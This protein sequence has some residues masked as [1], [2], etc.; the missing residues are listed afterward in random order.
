MMYR[1]LAWAAA[2]ILTMAGTASFAAGTDYGGYLMSG[3]FNVTTVLGPAPRPGDPRYKADRKIFLA[4]RRFAGSP[5]WDLAA[6]DADTSVPALLRNFSCSVGVELTPANSPRL[7]AVARRAAIDTSYQT[8]IAKEAYKRRRPYVIDRGAVCQPP[9]ELYDKKAQRMT[10]DYPSG[11]TTLGWTWAVVLSS[12]APDRAQQILERGRAY[13]DS[14][15]VCGVHNQ[16]AVEAG[17]LSASATMVLVASKPEYQ[18]DLVEARAEL[19]GLRASAPPA[20]DCATEFALLQQ[21]SMPKLDTKA[22][23]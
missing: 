8:R 7:V 6:N 5:R 16:S 21:R 23:R 15:L 18:S 2:A 19:A 1:M 20:Q 4:T 17:F 22:G 12:I 10:Y 13:G 9:S 14:R 3:E 11:H